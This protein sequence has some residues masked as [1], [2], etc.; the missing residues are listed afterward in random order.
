MDVPYDVFYVFP[1]ERLPIGK[2]NPSDN[3]DKRVPR[4]TEELASVSFEDD[5]S[6][7]PDY[8]K[9][10]HKKTTEENNKEAVDTFADFME[11]FNVD[12]E[13][14]LQE[15]T[16]HQKPNPLVGSM[17]VKEKHKKTKSGCVVV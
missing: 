14:T 8:T 6:I 9:Y 10:S 13:Q 2:Y 11:N 5:D 1:N 16:E 17:P 15:E 4:E 7:V 3:Q 12:M